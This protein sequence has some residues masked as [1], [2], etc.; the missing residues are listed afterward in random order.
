[1]D[2]SGEFS[3]E[4]DEFE[5]SVDDA[6]QK[7]L[8]NHTAYDNKHYDEAYEVSQDLSMAES[9]DG[10]DK[11]AKERQLKNDKYDEA[12]EVSQSM[13]QT[14]QSIAAPKQISSYQSETKDAKN[15]APFLGKETDQS[16]SQSLS[17]G[18]FD[19]AL[20]FSQSGSEESVETRGSRPN[21]PRMD[22][23]PEMKPIQQQQQSSS[24]RST[25]TMNPQDADSSP[26][27]KPMGG[28]PAALQ[29]KK[30]DDESSSEEEGDHEESYDNI[31]GAYNPKDY[32]QLNV[33]AEVRDLFQYIERYKPQE[34][35]LD[36]PLRCFIPEYIP[37]IGE[38]DAFIKIPRPD[39]KEDG[40][41]LRYLDEPSPNQS[42]PTV[43]ELQLRA[44]S[45]KLQYGDVVVRSIEHAD[46]NP[47][48]VEKWIQDIND[49]H[50]SKPPP[51]VNYKQN[52]P[53]FDKL[54][55]VWPE[56]FEQLLAT[57]PLPSPDLDLSLP[58]YAKVL[59]SILDIP[60]Y[61]NPIESLHVMFTL[62]I[63]FRNNPHFQAAMG[64]NNFNAEE[65]AGNYFGGADV[66]EIDQ[67]YK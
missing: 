51:Q 43:L 67:D 55:D 6:K 42:D 44:K 7:A 14:A 46:K 4:L 16:K 31:E 23:P 34:V 8:K 20:E 56:E 12:V 27:R 58:E 11:G 48:K 54:L 28:A 61:A 38:L 36:T 64:G 52:M 3:D 26:V 22:R 30:E 62:F 50:R 53:D 18:H 45:K 40:L 9:F 37:A 47:G 60:T 63:E 25:T 1:M 39:D 41:G 15:A 2:E 59:C 17:N 19:E 33:A 57:V 24:T 29:H 35:E 65:K 10:R 5:E 13:D 49:L 32:Q 21:K 66:L